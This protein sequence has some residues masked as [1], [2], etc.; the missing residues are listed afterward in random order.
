[1]HAPQSVPPFCACLFISLFD[2]C[3][4]Q[5]ADTKGCIVFATGVMRQS[6]GGGATT[7]AVMSGSSP[8]PVQPGSSSGG[9]PFC[10]CVAVK[11][12]VISLSIHLGRDSQEKKILKWNFHS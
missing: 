2:A 8:V 6:G 1:M 4:S 10:L 11:R 3:L 9:G 7:A 5:V 12:Q